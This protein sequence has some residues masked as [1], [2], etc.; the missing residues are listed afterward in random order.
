MGSAGTA[1]IDARRFWEPGVQPSDAATRAAEGLLARWT[2]RGSGSGSC[3]APRCV[4]T[5][6]EPSTACLV[7]GNLGLSPACLNFDLG[8]ACLAFINA[9][10]LAGAMIER[11]AVDYALIVD[12]ENSRHGSRPPSPGGADLHGGD[13]SRPVRDA[14]AGVGGGHAARPLEPGPRRAPIRRR[15]EPGGHRAQPPLHGQNDEMVTDTRTLLVEGL[16]LAAKTTPWPARRWAGGSPRPPPHPPGSAV[17]T[18]TSSPAR[19]GSP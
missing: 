8:N 15:G 5:S 6:W 17:C 18:P 1:G 16:K 7:H 11:R 13:V 14:D 3:S 12:G 4:A 9:M 10:D 2:C 19:C